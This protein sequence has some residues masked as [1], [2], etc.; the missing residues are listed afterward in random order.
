M[1]TKVYLAGASAELD[2]AKR[3]AQM[4]RDADIHVISTWV[5]VIGKVGAANPADATA[6]QLTKWTLRDL[7]EVKEADVLWLQ[8]PDAGINT[9]GA[10]I[11]L[12]IAYAS[13]KM[14][15]M[16]GIHRP[17][18]TPVLAHKHFNSDGEAFRWLKRMH[19]D[20]ITDK[21]KTH[22]SFQDSIDATMRSALR[23]G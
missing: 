13:Q 10:W 9:I 16:S 4:L 12:G 18:F 8:L 2:R 17:I 6:E 19:D 1:I 22:I 7:E 23:H 5:D 21:V 15:L 3:N 14:V 20:M 11:E